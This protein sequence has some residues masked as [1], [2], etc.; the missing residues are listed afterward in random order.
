MQKNII[1]YDRKPEFFHEDS[2]DSDYHDTIG[3]ICSESLSICI[4]DYSV[5][6]ED[7]SS[8]EA[9]ELLKYMKETKKRYNFDLS[10]YETY[11]D[12]S[13]RCIIK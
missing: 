3:A 10:D 4:N 6:T 5:S 8:S 7:M 1:L 2:L 12:F 13:S 11:K 9:A